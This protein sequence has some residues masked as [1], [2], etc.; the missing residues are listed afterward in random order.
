MNTIEPLDELPTIATVAEVARYLRCSRAVV[1]C[2]IK[3][4]RLPIIRLS[5][6]VWRISRAALE[7]WI[8][9]GRTA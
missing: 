1:Y 3:S 5:E 7:R 2:E 8:A 4:G 9:E 6:K